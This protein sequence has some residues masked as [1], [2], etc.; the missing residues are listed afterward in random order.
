[1]MGVK[2]SSSKKRKQTRLEVTTAFILDKKSRPPE[3]PPHPGTV[4]TQSQTLAQL[5]DAVLAGPMLALDQE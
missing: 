4:I 1:M 2:H 5:P 3:T